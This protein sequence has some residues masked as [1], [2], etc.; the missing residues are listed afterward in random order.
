MD[1]RRHHGGD[2]RPARP[3]S[4]GDRFLVPNLRWTGGQPCRRHLGNRHGGEALP[5]PL[6]V[7]VA[8]GCRPCRRRMFD[9]VAVLAPCAMPGSWRCRRMSLVLIGA[10]VAGEVGRS[11]SAGVAMQK[12]LHQA[13]AVRCRRIPRPYRQLAGTPGVVQARGPGPIPPSFAEWGCLARA[14]SPTR[15]ICRLPLCRRCFP[16]WN[17]SPRPSQP[18]LRKI[19]RKAGWRF[20]PRGS[21]RQRNPRPLSARHPRS[22]GR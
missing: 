17:L 10:E 13:R 4:A 20:R 15:R 1:T 6:H 19:T 2:G 9:T 14:E 3:R 8:R 7:R 5:S 11:M 16:E 22:P 21:H 12:A 18:S